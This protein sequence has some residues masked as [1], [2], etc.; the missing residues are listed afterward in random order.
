MVLG[1]EAGQ[2]MVPRPGGR[3]QHSRG[4]HAGLG[5]HVV[6][7]LRV[8]WLPSVY[9]SDE[10]S[11]RPDIGGH[12]SRVRFRHD[13]AP[14]AL[15]LDRLTP[16][17]SRA[18]RHPPTPGELPTR[19]VTAKHRA[20][21]HRLTSAGA[22]SAE[23]ATRCVGRRCGAGPA[24][25]EDRPAT[26][27][28]GGA[29]STCSRGRCWGRRRRRWQCGSILWR[30]RW[31]RGERPSHRLGPTPAALDDGGSRL[32]HLDDWWRSILRRHWPRCLPRR[33]PW[34]WGR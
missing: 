23:D 25:K 34:H 21:A 7:S 28:G 8:G 24:T 2:G 15:T 31:G 3:D 22:S 9:E 20:S 19:H 12:S 18:I 4:R 10:A 27:R 6:E 17:A 1:A 16:F 29:G 32:V 26:P 13:G 11:K 5:G 30:R 33:H 14:P